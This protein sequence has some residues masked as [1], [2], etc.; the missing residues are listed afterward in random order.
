M[1]DSTPISSLNSDSRDSRDDNKFVNKLMDKYVAL[2]KNE[3]MDVANMLMPRPQPGGEMMDELPPLDRN[4][5][6]MEEKFENRDLNKDI[7]QLNAQDPILMRQFEQELQ[8][9]RNFIK[10]QNML[11]APEGNDEDDYDEYEEM[12]YEEPLWR[13]ILNEVR[14]PFVIIFYIF[15]SFHINIGFDK[16]L[17]RYPLL[18]NQHNQCYWT[19]TLLKAVMVGMLSYVTLRYIKI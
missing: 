14:I 4:Q 17:C 5:R 3:Q 19:G 2:E 11:D 13:K 18:G 15:I 8:N 9:S 6:N 10:S 1:D 7:F 16:I 12:E